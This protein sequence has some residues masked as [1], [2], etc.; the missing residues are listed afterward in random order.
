MATHRPE[1]AEYCHRLAVLAEGQVRQVE[2]PENMRRSVA[3]DI[4]VFAGPNPEGL[5]EQI[6]RITG[7]SP[8]LLDGSIHLE[9]VDG[10]EWI[11]KIISELPKGAIQSVSLREPGLGDAFLKLTGTSLTADAGGV[12]P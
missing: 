7:L 6:A 10:H 4:L 5:S 8:L 2:T 9:C 3:N 12:T 1:E 11:P